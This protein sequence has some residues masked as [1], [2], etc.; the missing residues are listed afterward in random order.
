MED[1]ALHKV[2]N[3]YKPPAIKAPEK[4]L[5]DEEL[6]T[7]DL[8]RKFR[9]ILN[10]LTPQKYS[11]LIKQIESLPID[12]RDRLEKILNLVFD[13]A[14]SEPAFCIEYAKVCKHLSGLKLFVKDE[15]NCDDKGGKQEDKKAPTE[16]RRMLLSKSQRWTILERFSHRA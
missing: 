9:G 5:D 6:K 7:E 2:D 11:D 12:T 15:A 8:M 3:A 4:P 1:V 16:F 14:L 13:K 10:K